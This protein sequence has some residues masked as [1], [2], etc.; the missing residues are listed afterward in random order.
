[1][2]SIPR[3]AG[4]ALWLGGWL[5]GAAA[6]DD[7]LA[8]L[9]SAH[10]HVFIGLDTARPLGALEALGA[11]RLLETDVALALT[12][13][14]DPTGLAGP[15]SFN[16]AVMEAGEAVLLPRAGLGIIP[17]LVGGAVEW[18][19]SAANAPA[20]ID[21]RGARQ[22]LRATLLEVTAELAALQIATWGSE[23]PDLLINPPD[24][25]ALPSAL[26]M[27]E[28]EALT[29]AVR[30]LEI[31]AAASRIEPGAIS[32]AERSQFEQAMRRLNSAARHA[33]VAICG[34]GSDSL[35]SP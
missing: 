26:A 2:T 20:P 14:G 27:A 34:S 1:V 10:H 30:C 8:A 11:I 24:P 15:P 18:R 33:L 21:S 23:I 35:T 12:A 4:L 28:A 22:Q 29:S 7:V 32:A 13:P 17:V 9:D 6:L 25:P 19:C 16:A 3:A 5:R 31:V